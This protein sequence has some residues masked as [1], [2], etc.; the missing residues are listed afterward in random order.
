MQ[1]NT[2]ASLTNDTQVS[3]AES[4][5][6]ALTIGDGDDTI[7]VEVPEALLETFAGQLEFAAAA[8]RSMVPSPPPP[9]PP[10]VGNIWGVV[11]PEDMPEAD[12]PVLPTPPVGTD[13]MYLPAGQDN[14][15]SMSDMTYHLQGVTGVLTVNPGVSRIVVEGHG[16][17]FESF[18]LPEVWPLPGSPSVT[19]VV[20][21]DATVTGDQSAGH[22]IRGTGSRVLIQRVTGVG[23]GI[24][25]YG[26]WCAYANDITIEDSLIQSQG[27]EAASRFVSCLRVA[28][29]RST[30]HTLA[31][32]HGLRVHGTSD[33][34][35]VY[36]SVVRNP[37]FIGYTNRPTEED[38]GR[39]VLT[40]CEV[41]GHATSGSAIEHAP[42]SDLMQFEMNDVTFHGA[43]APAQVAALLATAAV[44]P[45]WEMVNVVGL[46][47]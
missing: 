8:L 20:L 13:T 5:P 2:R 38:L 46:P 43:L 27:F 29:I 28:F 21:R 24:G 15:L 32:K 6:P 9:P 44:T 1:T 34:I 30:S 19:D 22:G 39:V 41:Y 36:D 31:D 17:A 40:R 25:K 12:R 42:P 35:H 33:E 23:S 47:S 16:Y 3:V 14:T 26:F 45:W 11:Y 18:Q 10:P 7:T 37:L 4:V